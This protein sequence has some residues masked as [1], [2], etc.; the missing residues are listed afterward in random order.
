VRNA[1]V[2]FPGLRR[3][4]TILEVADV[5]DAKPLLNGSDADALC[6]P[7]DFLPNLPDDVSTL[8]SLTSVESLRLVEDSTST[9]R[10]KV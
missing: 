2:E 7:V 10:R 6:S 1:G 3:G 4:V 9:M 8:Q 5:S